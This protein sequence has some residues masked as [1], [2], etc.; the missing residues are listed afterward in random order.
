[1]PKR[2]GETLL[3]P[4]HYRRPPPM[5]PRCACGPPSCTTVFGLPAS[6]RARAADQHAANC[7]ASRVTAPLPAAILSAATCPPPPHS[8]PAACLDTT[9]RWA[10]G[11]AEERRRRLGEPCGP[12]CAAPASYPCPHVRLHASDP[13]PPRHCCCRHAAPVPAGPASPAPA[14]P[15]DAQHPAPPRLR[16]RP[17]AGQTVVSV[18]PHSCLLPHPGVPDSPVARCPGTRG[19]NP[20]H[21]ITAPALRRP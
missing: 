10:A 21:A 3:T 18:L 2:Q 9:W 12:T 8:L 6:W 1:M 15:V 19:S 7:A 11:R 5:P 17:S 16:P 20:T 4:R 13:T 14:P